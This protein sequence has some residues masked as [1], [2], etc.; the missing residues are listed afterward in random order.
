MAVL[1]FIV[2]VLLGA[3]ALVL[4][5]TLLKALV[6]VILQFLDILPEYLWHAFS[7]LLFVGIFVGGIIALILLT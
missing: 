7:I 1:M 5:Y 2:Y 3:V 6:N 4:G